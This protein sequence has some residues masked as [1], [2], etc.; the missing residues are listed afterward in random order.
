MLSDDFNR[1]GLAKETLKEASNPVFGKFG[2]GSTTVRFEATFRAVREAVV[3]RYEMVDE[4]VTAARTLSAE[5]LLVERCNAYLGRRKARDLY[6]IFFL[7][8]VARGD[9]LAE[10][11]VRH[12]LRRF[13]PAID[14][15]TLGATVPT[16]AVPTVGDMQEAVGRWAR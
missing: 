11:A 15:K 12:L 2:T 7:T 14:E 16:R 10:E 13:T 6:D 4:T 5:S 9:S 1:K 8:H 3:R